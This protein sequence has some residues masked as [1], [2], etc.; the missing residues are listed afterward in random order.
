[1]WAIRKSIQ[2][3]W[4]NIYN[5]SDWELVQVDILTFELIFDKVYRDDQ[6]IHDYQKVH[7]DNRNIQTIQ[8]QETDLNILSTNY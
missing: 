1:M 6:R 3:K 4:R 8:L 2:L 5:I 7:E